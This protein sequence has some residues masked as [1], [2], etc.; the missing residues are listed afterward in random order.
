MD[1]LARGVTI[2]KRI[3]TSVALVLLLAVVLLRLF[4]FGL[5]T[6]PQ[7]GMYP[8]FPAGSHVITLRHPYSNIAR[9]KRG[10][11]IAFLQVIDGV[12]YKFI[13]RV[14]GLPGESVGTSNGRLIVNGTPA[15]YARVGQ[16]QVEEERIGSAHDP[17][18]FLPGKAPIPDTTISV[19]RDACFVL[20]DNRNNAADGRVYGPV[21]FRNIVAKAL[22]SW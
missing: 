5:S 15:T 12:E 11:V 2:F 16:A 13:W 9:V 20:G 1:G 14:V 6:V 7:N 8:S 17:V 21:P 4:V 19:P 10:D 3:A 18:S 22:F